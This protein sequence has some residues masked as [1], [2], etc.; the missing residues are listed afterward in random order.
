M[1]NF[2]FETFRLGLRNLVLHKL[3]SFLT[4]LGI[5]L[6]VAAVI[7]MVAVGE[8][9]KQVALA[10]LR[11]LGAKNILIRST[12]PPQSTEATGRTSRV[13]SYGLHREDL[14]RLKT[15]PKIA[16]IVPMRDT[17][18]KVTH[19][20][21]LAGSAHAIGTVPEAFDV[22]NLPLARGY[23]FNQIHYDD[24][25]DVCVIGASV[26]KQLFPY[27]DPIGA[28]IQIGISGRSTVICTVI[29]VLDPTGVRGEGQKMVGRDLDDDVYFPLSTA[30]IAFG[31]AVLNIKPGGMERKII[32]LSEIWI[33]VQEVDDVEL[34][35]SIAENTVAGFHTASVDYVVKAPIE[36]LRAAEASARSFDFLIVSIASISLLVGGIGIM[37]IM[38]ATVTERTREIGIRRALGA[39]QR[40]ITLQFL[41]ETTVISLTGGSIGITAGL[42]AAKSVP[43]ISRLLKSVDEHP[44]QIAT[45]SVLGSFIISGVIGVG[46]GLYPAM[47]A[48][49]M[50]PIEALRHE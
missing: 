22:I 37:N 36:I 23:Y 30:R 3:R 5:I 44:V 4:A 15:L 45:W 13:L 12:P 24:N 31:D 21:L 43:V 33:Q 2:F 32:E 40:H 10:Q 6:G 38:L 48:A 42:L 49:R 19:A 16:K 26:A 9:A 8:G 20:G 46:F 27:E 35:A 14:D 41:I 7:C 18:Q 25:A 34:T 47:M 11:Q 1:F 39:K 29:G 28:A 17:E 50:N